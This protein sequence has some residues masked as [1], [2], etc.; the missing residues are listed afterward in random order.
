MGLLRVLQM[1]ISTFLRQFD[2]MHT[3]ATIEYDTVISH[4]PS[5]RWI[6]VPLLVVVLYFCSSC[7]VFPYS[8]H[9]PTRK[10]SWI[11][12]AMIYLTCTC[13]IQYCIW[14]AKATKSRGQ[15]AI[16]SSGLVLMSQTMSVYCLQFETDD[17]RT[18][19]KPLWA[20]LRLLLVT[21][22]R[23]PTGLRFFPFF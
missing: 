14:H 19:E 10:P 2:L 12:S 22:K 5:F 17:F 9:F 13:A 6:S 21:R 7:T 16:L 23:Y 11:L 15:K 18:L 8:G 3:W 4:P 1:G 20:Q